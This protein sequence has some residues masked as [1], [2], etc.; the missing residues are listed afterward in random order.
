MSG[1]VKDG[2]FWYVAFR[3]EMTKA[4]RNINIAAVVLPFVAFLAAIPMLW[5]DL[6]GPLD[7]ILLVTIYAVSTVG[8]T[9]GYHRLLTHRAFATYKPVEY[10]YAILGSLAVEGPVIG[11]VSDHRKHHTFPDAEGD[12]H[13][14]HVDHHGDTPGP[15]RGLWHAHVGWL[16]NHGTA[17]DAE[18][19][20]PDLL[21]DRG[22]RIIHRLFPLWVTLGLVIP[23]GHRLARGRQPQERA[24][25]VLLGRPRAHVPR[26]PRDVLDQLDLPLL[27]APPLRDRG[28]VHERVLARACRRSASPGTTTTTP[29]PAPRCTGCAGGRSTSAAW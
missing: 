24:H 3:Y 2:H 18:K 13:S 19:Y 14:P 4:H 12:P 6:V 27:R 25:R 10:L 7:L 26:P 11:W 8:I 9:V 29:S 5:N 20:A 21:E 17:V 23:A 15:L 22:M 16:F 1:G 28:Q